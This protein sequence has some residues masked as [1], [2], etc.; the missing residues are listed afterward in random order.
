MKKIV[1]FLCFSFV[2]LFVCFW[3]HYGAYVFLYNYVDLLSY[4]R[5]QHHFYSGCYFPLL[6]KFLT[7]YREEK[8]T[9][10]QTGFHWFIVCF[11]WESG[12]ATYFD[13]GLQLDQLFADFSGVCFY[14]FACLCIR[15]FRFD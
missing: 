13:R 11:T 6:Y 12:Q 15:V 9:L 8:I 7:T 14:F 3:V 1:R 2:F 5:F 4:H 10:F